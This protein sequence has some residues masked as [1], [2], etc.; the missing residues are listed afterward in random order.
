M[1]I[2]KI[3]PALI[4]GLVIALAGAVGPAGATTP[5]PIFTTTKYGQQFDYY[6][7]GSWSITNL[8]NS[9]AIKDIDPQQEVLCSTYDTGLGKPCVNG[10]IYFFT[11]QSQEGFDSC[12]YVQIVGGANGSQDTVPGAPGTRVCAPITDPPVTPPFEEREVCAWW[13]VIDSDASGDIWEQTI[14]S[15]D[16]NFVPV[17]ECVDYQYQFDKYWIR[18]A[19]DAAYFAALTVLNS[20]ADDAQ[21]EPHDYRVETV[22]A[23]DCT[24]VPPT[25]P[26]G[27]TNP[28]VVT[29]DKPVAELQ[30]TGDTG[31][32]YP[33]LLG[34][35]ILVL[36]M[37]GILLAAARKRGQLTN[38]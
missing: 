33:F 5:S 26:P 24:V 3:I 22:E 30:A 12:A 34:V 28:P 38:E 36:I 32:N 23:K 16:C 6:G 17:P 37:A 27:E 11:G 20:P 14:L 7:S 2:L 29:E 4:V 19:A 35:A 8:D 21:L 15:K 13:K 18:D 1:K 31:M 10:A 25:N 9:L